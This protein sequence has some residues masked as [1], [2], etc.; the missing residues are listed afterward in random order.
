LLSH[1][2][3]LKKSFYMYPEELKRLLEVAKDIMR[4]RGE[5]RVEK[6]DLGSML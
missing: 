5:K 3:F 2:T 4:E 1:L 6:E